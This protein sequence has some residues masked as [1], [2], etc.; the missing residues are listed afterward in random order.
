MTAAERIAEARKQY[1]ADKY[2]LVFDESGGVV[3]A[4]PKKP[5]SSF[6]ELETPVRASLLESSRSTDIY[7][8]RR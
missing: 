7:G 5:S 1:P 3:A 6:A 2:D 4:T 8:A